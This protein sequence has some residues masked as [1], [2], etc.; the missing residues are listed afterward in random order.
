MLG[1][2]ENILLLIL[3]LLKGIFVRRHA[4][5][6]IGVVTQDWK[7]ASTSARSVRPF[8]IVVVG[9]STLVTAV[10][11][12]TTT[13]IAIASTIAAAVILT[14]TTTIIIAITIVIVSTYIGIWWR[15]R[16]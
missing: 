14:V 9:A 7:S 1:I 8:V 16:W 13:T 5:L 2:V 11:A 10:I 6:F 15:G 4:S 12:I 3:L